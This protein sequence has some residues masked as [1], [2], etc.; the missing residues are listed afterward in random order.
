MKRSSDVDSAPY[1]AAPPDWPKA[2]LFSMPHPQAGRMNPPLKGGYRNVV[3]SFLNEK[4]TCTPQYLGSRFTHVGP[5]IRPVSRM[6]T[7][8]L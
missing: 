7:L 3:S 6:R 8:E 2:L 1:E 4:D 5:S